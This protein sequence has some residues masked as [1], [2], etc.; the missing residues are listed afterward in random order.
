ML[1]IAIML[2]IAVIAIASFLAA[3]LGL[4][5]IFSTAGNVVTS[6]VDS[7]ANLVRSFRRA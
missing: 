4:K 2:T 6:L 5:T 7:L 3:V 1:I